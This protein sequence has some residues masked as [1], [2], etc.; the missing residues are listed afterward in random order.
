MTST[1]TLY[2]PAP[3]PHASATYQPGAPLRALC[4]FVSPVWTPRKTGFDPTWEDN[5]GW[6]RCPA[7]NMTIMAAKSGAWRIRRGH[8]CWDLTCVKGNHLNP[9]HQGYSVKEKKIFFLLRSWVQL[10]GLTGISTA[11][12]TP[13]HIIFS[14]QFQKLSLLWLISFKHYG[15]GT[16][17]PNVI[18]QRPR[19]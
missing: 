17:L 4:K 13:A 1:A 10:H 9:A 16:K 7:V 15:K 5:G 2:V 6:G 14:R 11:P 12:K 18:K 8:Q 19:C 3:A